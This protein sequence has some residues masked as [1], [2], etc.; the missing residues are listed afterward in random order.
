M[1]GLQ[2]MMAQMQAGGG[3]SGAAGMMGIGAGMSVPEV[4]LSAEE[5]KWVTVY[6]IY[7]DAKRRFEKGCRRVAYQEACLWPKSDEIERAAAT[8][9]LMHAHEPRKA[10]PRDWENPGRVKVQL[11]TDEGKPLNQK[12]Q[13]KKSLLRAIAPIIQ[14][15]CG[16]RP[17]PL[18][19]HPKKHV[20][21]QAA[22]EK[23][24]GNKTG[25]SKAVSAKAAPVTGS[26]NSKNAM[27]KQRRSRHRT[28]IR[29]DAQD[30]I[31]AAS[32]QSRHP[33]K[34][35]LPPYSPSREAGVLNAD[36]SGMMGG[37][38]GMGPLGA[39]MGSMGMGDEEE[40][41]E[42]E[43]ANKAEEKKAKDPLQQLSRRQRKRVIRVGR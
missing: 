15:S 18:P 34:G 3:P 16:G 41:G 25:N 2:Q 8:L 35:R 14:P 10:H 17:P 5:K 24:P 19:A 7:F 37:L 1:D 22:K 11:F 38:Q 31:K 29:I 4:Q 26:Q 23:K 30:R 28:P 27:A 40:Q 12:I 43:E 39:M 33:S 6:P 9:T 20:E 32:E 42:G 13:T 36:F 21:T